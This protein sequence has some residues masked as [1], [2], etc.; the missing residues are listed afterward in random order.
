[1]E[2]KNLFRIPISYKIAIGIILVILLQAGMSYWISSA[3]FKR[4]ALSEKTENIQ[5][6][7][8]T[9]QETLQFL[10][11]NKNNSQLQKTVTSLG[12]HIDIKE[13]FLLNENNI[14][15]ASTRIDLIG[16][17][18]DTIFNLKEKNELKRRINLLRKKLKNILWQSEDAASLYAISPIVLG[19][20]SDSLLRSDR[21]GTLYIHTDMSLTNY[22]TQ[23]SIR[24]RILPEFTILI[25]AGIMLVLFFNV[26]ISR[27]IKS[28][29]LAATRFFNKNYTSRIDATGNDEI[30]D[31]STTFNAMAE[32]VE[33]QLLEISA[34]EKN[35]ALT[36][37]QR[38]HA[39]AELQSS[40][41]QVHLLLDSTAEAIYGVD[42]NG[43]CS[44]VNK[45]CLSFLGY[46][47]SNELIGKN[48]HQLIHYQYADGKPYPLEQ[49]YLYKSFKQGQEAHVDDEVLW[50]KDGSHFEAEYWAHP[51]MENN[52]CIGSVVTF[53][54]ITNRKQSE[55]IIQ[56]TQKMDALGKLTGGIAH[57][58]NNML[59]VILGYAELLEKSL[60]NEPDKA[61]FA[62]EITQAGLRGAKLT[63]KLLSF[64]KYE[65][66]FYEMVDLNEILQEQEDMLKKTLTVRINLSFDLMPE[67]WPVYIDVSD[68]ENAVIN[69]SI[70]AMHSIAE[71]GKLIIKTTNLTL[72]EQDA[73]NIDLSAGDYVALIFTDTG[74]GM[75]AATIDKIFD[76]FY[77]T[78]G[79]QGTGLGLSQVYGFVNRSNGAINVNSVPKHGTQVTIYLPRGH[80]E[81]AINSTDN[82][83]LSLQD[84]E[85]KGQG[86]ILIVDDEP[87]LLQLTSNILK[88]F[89]YNTRCAENAQIALEILEKESF[90]ILLSDVIMPQMDGYQL[91]EIVQQK[92]PEIKIQLI[93]GFND[94]RHIELH[95]HD[96]YDN[97]LNKPF[98]A[99]ELLKRMRDLLN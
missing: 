43:L 59:G 37:E 36:L 46:E 90:D 72:N 52:T 66:S 41:S 78:K 85:L 38:N 2:D 3:Q 32:K 9:L 5:A 29:N 95:H 27:R 53:L 81:T 76:P 88:D 25:L 24:S 57:D 60:E 10:S 56:R 63:K 77:S 17:H 19:R 96:L 14:V 62:H 23:M 40:Q 73:K 86:S 97:L 50:R 75:D 16:K 54:D 84:T 44:F 98:K 47:N 30:S 65:I 20:S 45:A 69:L 64:S 99:G 55:A 94:D 80:T 21:I 48:M 22:K 58:Y 26:G 49:S 28:I 4:N 83:A 18:I 11:F 15:T 67:L 89:G 82:Q 71:Q 35:L 1:M 91:A 12:A 61:K 51:I 68:L 93:S 39:L 70:N 33:E 7:L 42:T 31:L 74:C 8:V 13:A 92:Y 6:N 34:R 79:D 87:T